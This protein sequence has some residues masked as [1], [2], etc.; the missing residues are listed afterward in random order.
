MARKKN[1]PLTSAYVSPPSSG[2]SSKPRRNRKNRGKARVTR[3]LSNP[4]KRLVMDHVAAKVMCSTTECLPRL[5]DADSTRV[6]VRKHITRTKLTTDADGHATI[7]I[8]A[9]LEN[10]LN[11]A[12]TFGVGT[13]TVATWGTWQQANYYVVDAEKQYRVTGMCVRFYSWAS[14][15]NSSGVITLAVQ[16]APDRTESDDKPNLFDSSLTLG[17][18]TEFIRL[19]QADACICVKPNDAIRSC[20]YITSKEM[21][22]PISGNNSNN[23]NGWPD[24][25]VAIRG[26]PASI[27]VGE[28]V[29]EMT[30]EAY[31]LDRGSDTSATG[32]L[33]YQTFLQPAAPNV[34]LIEQ[35]T[36]AVRDKIP[37]I[38]DN[39][40][41]PSYSKRTVWETVEDVAGKFLTAAA[42]YALEGL[43]ALLL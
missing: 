39:S 28:I 16:N 13:D 25:F 6:L 17:D 31:P 43:A 14:P 24:S 33:I 1:Q 32:G 35:I 30:V 12:A 26:G 20:T 18:T 9:Q 40:N 42:P 22:M 19:Y 27:D 15:T 29:V 23:Y 38:L 36:S 37:T 3:Q 7:A 21:E 5:F 8:R 10:H 41:D 34:P 4:L 2:V 11:K